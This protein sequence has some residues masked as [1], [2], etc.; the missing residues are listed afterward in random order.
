MVAFDVARRTQLK[1]AVRAEKTI[2]RGAAEGA[3]LDFVQ[4]FTRSVRIVL[5]CCRAWEARVDDRFYEVGL[6][7]A[8]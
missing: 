7:E 1:A 3:F 8:L 2:G 4:P 5:A 6:A